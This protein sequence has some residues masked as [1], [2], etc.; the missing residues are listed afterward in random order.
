VERFSRVL[1]SSRGRNKK[2][3]ACRINSIK[4][5]SIRTRI[6][7]IKKD[8]NDCCKVCKE[9]YY[10]KKNKQECDWVKAQSVEIG[11][12]K[13]AECSPKPVPIVEQHLFLLS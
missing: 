6:I 12:M 13:T 10:V 1:Q 4:Y 2:L 9:Y 11:C 7:L 3:N 5:F 8:D